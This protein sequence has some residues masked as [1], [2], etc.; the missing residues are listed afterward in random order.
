MK[1]RMVAG[2]FGSEENGR[3]VV[4]TSED[5]PFEVE[6]K[7]GERLIRMEVAEEVKEYASE[8]K[9]EDARDGESEEHLQMGRLDEE[10]LREMKV[11]DLRN[12]ADEMGLKKSGSKEELID[13][14]SAEN[15]F[16]GD[17]E[18]PDMEAEEPE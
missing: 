14:I 5:L 11:E 16:Y 13:R 4:K 9:A 12:L 1:I 6:Q 15:A 2:M 7:T 18:F 8:E 17:D 10:Q 3:I